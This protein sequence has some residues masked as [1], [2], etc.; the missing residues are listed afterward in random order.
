MQLVVLSVCH[1]QEGWTI[2]A[3][4]GQDVSLQCGVQVQGT[5]ERLVWKLDT[6]STELVAYS[7][8]GSVSCNTRKKEN[9][10]LRSD[11]S[12]E[13]HNLQETDSGDYFCVV[14]LDEKYYS[15]HTLVVHP[16]VAFETFPKSEDVFVAQT[17]PDEIVLAYTYPVCKNTD[18]IGTVTCDP[19][20]GA[21]IG[22][23]VTEIVCN[24]IHSGNVVDTCEIPIPD[25]APSYENCSGSDPVSGS[26]AV[27]IVCPR[28]T[29]LGIFLGIFIG[30]VLGGVGRLMEYF[31]K[32]H[33]QKQSTDIKKENGECEEMLNETVLTTESNE[34]CTPQRSTAGN[35]EHTKPEFTSH[36]QTQMTVILGEKLE[37]KCPVIGYPSPTILWYKDGKQLDPQAGY[38]TTFSEGVAMLTAESTKEGDEGLFSCVTVNPE[39]DDITSC[40]VLVERST[41]IVQPSDETGTLT[42]ALSDVKTDSGLPCTNPDESGNTAVDTPDSNDQTDTQHSMPCC[43]EIRE[44]VVEDISGEFRILPL[45]ANPTAGIAI[46]CKRDENLTVGFQKGDLSSLPKPTLDPQNG[47]MSISVADTVAVPLHIKCLKCGSSLCTLEVNGGECSKKQPQTDCKDTSTEEDAGEG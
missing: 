28:V 18:A 10:D 29:A 47:G 5:F 31:Y 1:A 17:G 7:F 23:N 20:P 13:L 4:V 37:L 14:G 43:S 26:K 27:S 8:G 35:K 32:K 12:L 46:S 39:G 36:L 44:F 15:Q 33:S 6:N 24:C 42:E 45:R 38:K 22:M 3:A 2:D 9:C 34:R 30:A 11:G 41:T 21:K 16:E 19:P 40:N 25:V